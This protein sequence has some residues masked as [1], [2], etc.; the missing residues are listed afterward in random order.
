MRPSGIS[1]R[2]FRYNPVLETCN[3]LLETCNALPK[4]CNALPKTCNAALKT[5]NA[6]LKTCNAVSRRHCEEVF[7]ISR[8][9]YDV[10]FLHEALPFFISQ[11]RAGTGRPF[12]IQPALSCACRRRMRKNDSTHSPYSSLCSHALPSPSDLRTNLHIPCCR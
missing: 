5:C 12:S 6:A 7:A 1:G 2:P 4:T 11:S 8:I 9:P 10:H 3:A